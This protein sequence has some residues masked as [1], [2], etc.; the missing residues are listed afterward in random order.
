[1]P[2]RDVFRRRAAEL[3]A[4]ARREPQLLMQR[5]MW[6]LA[7]GKV[8]FDLNKYTLMFGVFCRLRNGSEFEH[9]F[10]TYEQAMEAAIE[11]WAVQLEVTFKK[12]DQLSC[13][14][15]VDPELN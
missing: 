11:A 4:A 3:L 5:W 10:D 9:A 14:C 1:M 13:A 7:A 15:E 6:H 2:R 12:L 8:D